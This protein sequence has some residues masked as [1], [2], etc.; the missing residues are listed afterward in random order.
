MGGKSVCKTKEGSK[1]SFVK[2]TEGKEVSIPR[3]TKGRDKFFFLG[4]GGNI[5]V[6]LLEVPDASLTEHTSSNIISRVL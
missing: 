6:G 3:P 1:T 5:T 4:R 2:V